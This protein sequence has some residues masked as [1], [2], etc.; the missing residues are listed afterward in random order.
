ML[1]ATRIIW[2]KCKEVDE[3]NEKINGGSDNKINNCDKLYFFKKRNPSNKY[4]I[5]F[6]KWLISIIFSCFIFLF[7]IGL[8]LFGFLIFRESNGSGGKIEIK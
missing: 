4:K 6:D 1:L 8:A 7:D 2:E 3:G 5:I